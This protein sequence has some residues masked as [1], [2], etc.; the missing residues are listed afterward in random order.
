MALNVMVILKLPSFRH[1]HH[2]FEHYG[3]TPVQSGVL[4]EFTEVTNSKVSATLKSL[5]GR[6]WCG[7]QNFVYKA[8]EPLKLNLSTHN[9][10]DIKTNQLE[11]KRW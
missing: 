6:K 10:N 11:R 5:K 1:S 2:K 3:G 8:L 9:I 4:F 7:V